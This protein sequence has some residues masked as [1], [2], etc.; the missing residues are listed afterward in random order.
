[1]NE[2]AFTRKGMLQYSCHLGKGG[3][4]EIAT[5]WCHIK[6]ICY[7]RIQPQAACVSKP[8]GRGISEPAEITPGSKGEG[9]EAD[10]HCGTGPMSKVCRGVS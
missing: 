3:G 9:I 4:A 5:R 8:S 7:T 1:M 6:N 2:Q 10:D